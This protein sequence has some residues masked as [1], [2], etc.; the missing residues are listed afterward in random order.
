MRHPDLLIFDRLYIT[1]AYRAGVGLAEYESVED[2]LKPYSPHTII[3]KVSEDTI[4]PRIEAASKHRDSKWK[5]YLKTKGA[6][7]D[8]IADYYI[9][10]QRGIL[11]L[12]KQSM[13]PYTV[14]DTTNH[15]Y[16]TVAEEIITIIRP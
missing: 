15:D 14:F 9:A 2:M 4:A 8:E 16:G 13:L 12:A 6:T 5:D 10:Q 7:F 3:L 11:S 1:Q